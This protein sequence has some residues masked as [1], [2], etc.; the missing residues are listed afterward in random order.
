MRLDRSLYLAVGFFFI[1]STVSPCHEPPPRALFISVVEDTPVLSSR[2][3][4]TKL[5][6]FAKRAQIKILFVQVYHG[7][8][9]W[10]PSKIADDGP[11][12][13]FEKSRCR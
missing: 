12:E 4:I 2:T 11:Y 9:S 13:G 10:F 7:G 5:I 1:F 3:E 6:D 8:Q